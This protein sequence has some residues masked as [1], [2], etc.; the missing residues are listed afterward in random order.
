MQYRN[1]RETV[2]DVAESLWHGWWWLASL[3]TQRECDPYTSRG[4]QN[5]ERPRSNL[6]GI[7]CYTLNI[8]IGTNASK[9]W[10]GRRVCW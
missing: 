6:F 4:V 8:F 3:R 2:T 1:N 9:V 10:R 5:F 7:F